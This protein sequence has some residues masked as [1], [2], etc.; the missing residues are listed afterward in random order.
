MDTQSRSVATFLAQIQDSKTQLQILRGHYLAAGASR[1]RI[2]IN[3]S[4]R[5][6]K[7]HG[8][9]AATEYDGCLPMCLYVTT[10]DGREYELG[11]SLLWHQRAW[12]IETE[13]R[14]ESADG[15]WD[16]VHDLPARTAED[17]ASCLQQVQAAIADLAGFQ[18]RIFGR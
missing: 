12:R 2:G 8:D 7:V 11:A 13:L 3:L 9:G 18:D 1:A 6:Y 14:Q 10:T 15:S 4:A 5:P 16:L 17:L